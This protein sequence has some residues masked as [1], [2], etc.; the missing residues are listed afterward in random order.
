MANKGNQSGQMTITEE[1]V[2]T[3]TDVSRVTPFMRA[4]RAMAQ[5]AT[6]E[7]DDQQFTGDDV[8]INAMLTAETDDEIWD[9]DERGPLGFR[10]LAGCEIAILDVQ[11]K[12]SRGGNDIKT[13]FVTPEGK[14]MYLLATCVRLN[15]TGDE[16]A[17]IRLPEIGEVFQANTSARYTVMKIWA[18]Y[19]KGRIS[20]VTGAQLECRVKAIDLGEGQAVVKL[21]PIPKRSETVAG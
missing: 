21:R 10:D 13:V 5:E 20:P 2:T 12:L 16:D 18:F 19:L 9:A 7:P 3:V 6:V 17:R 1:D 15:V 14:Q 8:A 11:V 4:I